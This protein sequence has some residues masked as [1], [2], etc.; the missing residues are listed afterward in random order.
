MILLEKYTYNTEI[1]GNYEIILNV[2]NSLLNK[3][4]GPRKKLRSLAADVLALTSTVTDAIEDV[5]WGPATVIP[6]LFDNSIYLVG[7]PGG[8]NSEG[9]KNGLYHVD[10]T[11]SP[12]QQPKGG[13]G[14][15]WRAWSCAYSPRL[16][17]RP[18]KQLEH[19][20]VPS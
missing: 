13:E 14:P 5:N 15:P 16:H 9:D 3:Q 19:R 17:P 1:L 20:L 8:K 7:G 12:G 4:S 11:L 6:W 10:S 18:P 2:V